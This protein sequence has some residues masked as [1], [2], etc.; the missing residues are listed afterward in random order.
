MHRAVSSSG[1]AKAHM[2][3]MLEDMHGQSSNQAVLLPFTED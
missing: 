3:E 2:E 1:D